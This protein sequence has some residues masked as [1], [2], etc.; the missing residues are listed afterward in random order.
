MGIFSMKKSK[1]LSIFKRF[2]VLV[3]KMCD[4]YVKHLRSEQGGEYT[5]LAFKNFC[6]EHGIRHFMTAPD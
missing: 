1:A 3:E 4:Y 5:S 2:K 6:H